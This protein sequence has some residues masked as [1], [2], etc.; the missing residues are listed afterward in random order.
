MHLNLPSGGTL[1]RSTEVLILLGLIRTRFL[2]ALIPRV[3][4]WLGNVNTYAP[5]VDPG[6]RPLSARPACDVHLAALMHPLHVV[7]NSTLGQENG[8]R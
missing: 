6:N 2:D 7:L 1:T 5:G 3:G 4:R 8:S